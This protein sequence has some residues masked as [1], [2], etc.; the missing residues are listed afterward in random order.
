MDIKH[1]NVSSRS[2]HLLVQLHQG[3]IHC[4][5]IATA[6]RLLPGST[7]DAVKKL[8]SE[9]TKRGLLMRVKEALYFVIPYE[10]DAESFM[11]DWHVLAPCLVGKASYY[12]G[13]YTA[14]QIHGLTTQPNLR[15]QI[16]VDTQI[17]PAT[18]HIKGI[19]F[20]FIYHNTS[21][22]FGYR[23]IW[24]D[25]F[26]KVQCSDI[27]K[28]LIDCLFKP[29]YGGGIT[30]ITR[31]IYKSKDS[32]DY[33]KLFEYTRQF[34]SQAVMK[35]L[36][37]LLELLGIQHSV[38]EEWQKRISKSFVLLDPSY[39]KEGKMIS[40]WAIQQNIDTD[41]LLSPLDS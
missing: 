19:P 28:T 24:V 22:F 23:K 25:S 17:K 8:L 18:I 33:L 41:S 4:F 36:G 5:D 12:L 9:M 13:Y 7:S 37:F 35:R 27:E 3:N 32:L 39:P 16:V 26:N 6:Y 14:L 2:A 10:Q 21:H 31:A 38:I 15:E 20:Q 34:Q 1:K 11:P 30:E 40:R 29:E